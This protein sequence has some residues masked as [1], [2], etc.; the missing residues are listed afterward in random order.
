[1]DP[2]GSLYERSKAQV[3]AAQLCQLSSGLGV[4]GEEGG[5]EKKNKQAW[6]FSFFLLGYQSLISTS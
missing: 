3:L 2:D 1:M 6:S 5:I 4:G